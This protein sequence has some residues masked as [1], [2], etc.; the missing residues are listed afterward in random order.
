MTLKSLVRRA[1]RRFRDE[2]HLRAAAK[3]ADAFLVSYPKSGRTWLRFLLS[4]YF[5]EV[6]KLGFE[7]DLITTFRVLPNFDRDPVRGIGAFAW[8]GTAQRLPLIL[9]SHLGFAARLFLD[10]S[11]I[12]L[13]RDPRDV[14]VSAYFH[15]TR[16]KK[17]FAGDIDAF[18][19]NPTYGLPA[20]FRFLNGWA[21]GLAAR[22]HILVSYE[23][24]L[25]GS[26]ETVGAILRFV[27]VPVDGEALRR[28]IAAARF[29]RM[30]DKERDQGIP[31]HDYDRGDAQSMR[32]RSGKAGGF[33][34]LLT[35]EQ[36]ALILARCQRELS[37]RAR[38]L[39]AATGVPT[40]DLRTAAAPA[41][42]SA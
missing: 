17:V 21:G 3:R 23:E 16:H 38:A 6:A 26:E 39:L 12:F 32:M 24:M 28:A 36:S 5:A 29:D 13:V 4:C 2:P 31:G 35:P 14:I 9:V 42:A 22:R 20:L 40:G 7:P 41:M 15:A 18:L 37:P 19:D 34:E 27:G 11:V 30:R 33:D 25:D 10:R 1:R 8:G